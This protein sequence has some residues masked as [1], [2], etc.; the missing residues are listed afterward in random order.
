M[1]TYTFQKVTH[2]GIKG[3]IA[4]KRIDGLFIGKQFGK[5][6]AQ[7]IKQFEGE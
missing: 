1:V 6:K 7:A 2:N 5:T 3:Y 4:T